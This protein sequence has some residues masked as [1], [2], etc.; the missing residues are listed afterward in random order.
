MDRVR[1]EETGLS[2]GLARGLCNGV[3]GASSASGTSLARPR[4]AVAVLC[5]LCAQENANDVGGGEVKV[6]GRAEAVHFRRRVIT[7]GDQRQLKAVGH[8]L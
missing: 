4:V 6:F 7:Q 1:P 3:S 5:L 8:W 2:K